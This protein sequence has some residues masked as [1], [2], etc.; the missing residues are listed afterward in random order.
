MQIS[1]RL[2]L[3]ITNKKV[4]SFPMKDERKVDPQDKYF[5]ESREHYKKLLAEAQP[6]PAEVLT[7][8]K[9]NSLHSKNN[10]L[11]SFLGKMYTEMKKDSLSEPNIILN[12]YLK[13]IDSFAQNFKKF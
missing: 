6:I 8:P 3:N 9:I 13:Q 1:D 4:V 5:K 7:V 10:A 2:D 12:K 11:I